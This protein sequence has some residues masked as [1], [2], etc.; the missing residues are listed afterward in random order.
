MTFVSTHKPCDDCGSSDA[1]S[2]DDKG[3]STCFAC[4]RRKPPGGNNIV[5]IKPTTLD[6]GDYRPIQ[7]RRISSATCKLYKAA[8]RGTDL[9]LTTLTLLGML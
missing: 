4:N 8:Y 9:F 6:E 1:L 7:D 5:Q 3:W 2:I